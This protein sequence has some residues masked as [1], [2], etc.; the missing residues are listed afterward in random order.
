VPLSLERIALLNE[1]I[2]A[3]VEELAGERR[4]S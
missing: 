2:A 1:T 3:A 4:G